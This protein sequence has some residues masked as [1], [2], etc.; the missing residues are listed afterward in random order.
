[1]L[2]SNLGCATN[3][4]IAM[5]YMT[6]SIKCCRCC[7]SWYQLFLKHLIYVVYFTLST[8][9]N[10]NLLQWINMELLSFKPIAKKRNSRMSSITKNESIKKWYTQTTNWNGINDNHLLFI[11]SIHQTSI[12]MWCM[13]Y[14][15]CLRLLL[16]HWIHVVHLTSSAE[17]MKTC[18]NGLAR[19][20][21]PFKSVA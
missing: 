19:I 5:A 10:E 11:P 20:V 14:W 13:C 16:K 6:Q 18:C 9:S 12:N 21:F 17:S 3:L 8:N 7:K 1:M 4:Q 15:S 2:N